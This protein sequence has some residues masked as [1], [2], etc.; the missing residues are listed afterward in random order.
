MSTESLFYVKHDGDIF[1]PYD[2]S[3]LRALSL[4]PDTQVMSADSGQWLTAN[5]MPRLEGYLD[6]EG[7]AFTPPRF[8]HL[9]LR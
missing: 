8:N 3:T 9:I 6:T 5:Q 2:L 4:L 1:G 7:P